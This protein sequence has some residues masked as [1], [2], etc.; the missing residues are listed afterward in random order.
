MSVI[1]PVFNCDRYL[2]QCIISLVT[3]TYSDL[4]ILLVND[5]SSD[6]SPEI[7]NRFA[8]KF[9][10]VKVIHQKNSGVAIA[11]KVGIIRS[12]G[13]YLMFV[14][15]D[16]WIENDY[17]E[18][19]INTIHSHQAEIIIGT[20][21]SYDGEHF[22]FNKHYFASG[23][24]SEDGLKQ[25]IFPEMLSSEPHHTFGVYPS[26]WGK[27]FKRELAVN[28]L[29]S[30]DVGITFGEDGCFTYSA[31][32]DCTCIY[33]ADVDGYIYRTNDTSATHRFDSNWLQEGVKIKSF[34]SQ[35]IKEK[36]WDAG[37]QVDE[38]MAFLCRSIVFRAVRSPYIKTPNAKRNL[39]KYID[40]IFPKSIFQIPK[41][42]HCPWKRKI[43]YFLI[44]HRAFF[45]L[46][47]FLKVT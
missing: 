11:R 44:K 30:L 6:A 47:I 13:D 18:R 24:Y 40:S 36:N 45:L 21:K 14:D 41:V 8:D 19:M 39:V 38:Y 43:S 10:F 33:I 16:D 15:S 31:M 26:M 28:N 46:S 27:I 32:L 12:T 5:G 3:Q 34:F 35:L 37:T 4:E 23:L 17:I 7:C 1:V 25:I 29:N 42:N 2:E 9:S 20:F 22:S